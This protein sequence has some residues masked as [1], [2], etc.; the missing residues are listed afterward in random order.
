M[1][2]TSR[3][4]DILLFHIQND[5]VFNDTAVTSGWNQIRKIGGRYHVFRLE[6]LYEPYTYLHLDEMP[7]LLRVVFAKLINFEPIGDNNAPI[8]KHFHKKLKVA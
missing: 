1:I 6:N 4:V 5:I 3:E 2:N 7:G 8:P